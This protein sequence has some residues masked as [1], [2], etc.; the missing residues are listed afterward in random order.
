VPARDQRRAFGDALRG[1]DRLAL[2]LAVGDDPVDQPDA[3]RLLRAV[4]AALEQ[5]L[6]RVRRPDQLEQRLQLG[7]RDDEA[8]ARDGDAETRAR[9]TDPQVA[10]GRDL[11]AAA[12]AQ[13]ADLR[14]HRV[15]ALRDRVHRG[16]GALV[17]APRL[18]DRA[19]AL[20]ELADVGADAERALAGAG[21]D[22]AAQ[23]VVGIELGEQLAQPAP[24]RKVDGVQLGRLVERDLGDPARTL[25]QHE[26]G[27][28]APPTGRVSRSNPIGIC[29]KGVL[30]PPGPARSGAEA[31]VPTYRQASRR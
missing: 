15:A 30:M 19:A 26:V 5:D 28:Q 21:E 6:E 8:Q 4:H 9:A 11:Q 12:D 18:V 24:H 23:A 16:V 1:R 2:D 3:Q 27:H 29:R 14:D 13:A 17:I 31:A 7:V 25:E 22:D 20:L 10:H